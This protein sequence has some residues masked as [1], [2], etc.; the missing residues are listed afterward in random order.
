MFKNKITVKLFSVLLVVTLMCSL[1]LPL[2]ASA[3]TPGEDTVEEF[4]YLT[5]DEMKEL[6]Q[7]ELVAYCRA[8]YDHEFPEETNTVPPENIDPDQ[9][10]PQWSSDT[11]G[12]YYNPNKRASHCYITA[13]ALLLFII[14]FPEYCGFFN[15]ITDSDLIDLY[16]HSELPDSKQFIGKKGY[17]KTYHFYNPK[18]ALNTNTTA[19]Y[20]FTHFMNL[21]ISEMKA[22][23]TTYA[24]RNLGLALHYVQDVCEP[25]HARDLATLDHHNF[26]NWVVN[27]FDS[28]DLSVKT[29]SITLSDLTQLYSVTPERL[30]TAAAWSGYNNYSL[31]DKSYMQCAEASVGSAVVY[32]LHALCYF[33][34]RT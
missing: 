9:I 7:A 1:S 8:F 6:S 2:T 19:K 21:A 5:L 26:E 18:I 25:H 10:D 12:D 30:L 17:A 3:I 29:S 11:T 33:D 31:L 16:K 20:A 23:R 22:G 14:G 32:T 13:Y 27:N 28:I 4:H 34:M 15:T 24:V